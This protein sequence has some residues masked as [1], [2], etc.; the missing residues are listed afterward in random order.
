MVGRHLNRAAYRIESI[1]SYRDHK[2]DISIAIEITDEQ[3][4]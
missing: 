2:A 3:Y 4:F 1:R